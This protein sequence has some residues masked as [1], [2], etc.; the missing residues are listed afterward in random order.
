MAAARPV[1]ATD[2][3]G[4]REVIE[5]GESGYLVSSGDD[6]R[7]ATRIIALLRE[8]ERARQMGMRGR[9]IVEEKFSCAV[10]LERTEE[11]YDRALAAGSRLRG[12][13]ISVPNFGT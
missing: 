6:E 5:E 2:V 11:M 13:K 1:V 4:A 12:G 7:L 10:Q 9:R 3:G 8:P